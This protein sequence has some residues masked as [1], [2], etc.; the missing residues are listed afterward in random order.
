MTSSALQLLNI[1]I[2]ILYKAKPDLLLYREPSVS[3]EPDIGVTFQV[4]MPVIEKGVKDTGFI[5]FLQKDVS[6]K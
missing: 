3:Y 5:F 2:T 4:D 6:N 1:K